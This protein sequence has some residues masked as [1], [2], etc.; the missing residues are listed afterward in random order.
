MPDP[1]KI[2]QKRFA[3]KINA[4]FLQSKVC[5]NVCGQNLMEKN[6]SKKI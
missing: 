1:S 2:L 4:Y 5:E 6:K 3:L